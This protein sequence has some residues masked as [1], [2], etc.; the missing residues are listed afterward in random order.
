[1][2]YTK[3]Y[4][5][6]L[7]A[8]MMLFILSTTI[9]GVFTTK[10][11]AATYLI[12]E[13]NLYSKGEVEGF[14][15]NGIHIGVQF[16]VYKKDG[17]EYPAYCLNRNLPGVTE[18][19]QYTVT[20][21]KAVEN[22]SVWRAIVNGYPFKT[23]KQLGCNS[24]IEAF[25]AT[26]MAVYD[27]LYNYDWTAFSW[28]NEQGERIVKAAIKISTD[29]RNS[30]M[31]K[32]IAKVTVK[33]ISED[34]KVEE[35]DTNYISKTYQVE[36]NV[37]SNRYKVKL[38]GEYADE[39]LVTNENN[40][41]KEYYS[42]GEKFKVLVPFTRLE[43]EGKIEIQVT[44]DMETMPILYGKTADSSIQDYALAAG[45]ME[46]EQGKITIK[47]YENKTKI[48]I[49][50][51]DTETGENISGAKFNILNEKK[52]IVYSDVTTNSEG[53]AEIE[54]IRPGKYYIEEIKAPEG[55]TA[56]EE[57]IEIDVALN[58]TY[59]VN[60]ENY[61]KPEEE[62]KDVEDRDITVI[63]KKEIALPRTGF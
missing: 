31:T 51:K 34:W 43:Q 29:A 62:E 59:T 50:K 1:M 8:I 28:K 17:V 10:S 55:Y 16:V 36:T 4:Y 57:L 37:K 30:T 53:K 23:A 44:A 22:M 19:Q 42:S 54:N 40:E 15:Y 11:N 27:A 12:D 48:E 35:Y 46:Y 49:M 33:P 5:K 6:K 45:K 58:Q 39:M 56:Y 25:A 21:D 2:K 47:Y 61:K 26:K 52:D 24:N 14:S 18:S 20:V 3:K 41:W 7:I 63:G 13:A 9:M 32:P 60:V 38:V